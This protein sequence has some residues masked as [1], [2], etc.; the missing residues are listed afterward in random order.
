MWYPGQEGGRALAE[1]LF[2][3]VNP[4][5][6]LPVTFERRWEDNP[7]HDSYY[8][9]AGTNRVVYKEGVFVGYR[10][11]EKSGTKPLFPFGYGLSYTSFKYSNL[12]IKTIANADSTGP[13]YEVSFDMKNTGSNEGADVAQVYVGDTHAQVPRPAKE[14]KGFTKVSLRAG[15]TKRVTVTLDGRA[16]SYYDANG[17]QWRADA[18]DFEVL[19]GRSSEQIELRGKLTLATA[20]TIGKALEKK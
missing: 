1:V 17:K 2:G 14:L 3:E 7:V 16:L 19:V 6:R 12:Q 10:G 8:P 20:F 9:G 13:R 5:G 11:Y 15:E 4:S 18:G